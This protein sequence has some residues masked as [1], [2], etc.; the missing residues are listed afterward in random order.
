MNKIKLTLATVLA[1]MAFN[2]SADDASNIFDRNATKGA[3]AYKECFTGKGEGTEVKCE[4]VCEDKVN[5]AYRYMLNPAL[6]TVSTLK[7]FKTQV[8]D[9]SVRY[10]P[11]NNSTQCNA[12]KPNP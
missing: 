6:P 5:T 7:V 4:A 2:V 1:A 9:L 12:Y 11:S 3:E 10:S 8:Y